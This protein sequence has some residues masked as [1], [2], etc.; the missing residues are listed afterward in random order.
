MQQPNIILILTDH[1]RRDALTPAVAPNLWRLAGNGTAFAH[2]MS[3]SPLCQPARCSIISGMLPSHTGACGNQSNPLHERGD[4]APDGSPGGIDTFMHHFQRAGYTTA[5]IGKHHYIDRYGMDMDVKS[6][7]D[8]LKTYGF[9]YVCQVLDD[10]ESMHNENEYTAWLAGQNKLDAFRE[11][12]GTH[13]WQA[14]AMPFGAEAS[15]DAFI[16]RQGIAFIEKCEANKPFYLN[17]SFIGP[18]PPFWYGEDFTGKNDENIL[19]VPRGAENSPETRRIRAAYLAKCRLIDRAVGDLIHTLKVQNL[20]DNTV[21]VFTSDHGD[22][23]GDF[24]IWG[25]RYFYE[26]SVGVPL[27]ISGGPVPQQARLNGARVS[28]ALCSHLDLY[29][30]LLGLAGITPRPDQRRTGIDLVAMLATDGGGHEKIVAE[31]ATAMMIRIPHW[32]LVYDAEAGGV[33]QLFN[34]RR[35]KDELD[36]L[37]GVP[38]YEA[39]TGELVAQLLSDKIRRTQFTHVK[40]EQG[41]QE[42]RVP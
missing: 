11:C 29:P 26:S 22:C 23:L 7:N 32:K 12:F 4:W 41:L 38:G 8:A 20:Y 24:G 33:V 9:D 3:A 31:L 42:V 30:T 39:I 27:F 1:F 5:L 34:L 10:G 14:K 36:N 6:D 2:A 18:H 16:G 13:A 37:A 15:A 19:D 21:F 28:K 25:K 40:E 35:D 17:L